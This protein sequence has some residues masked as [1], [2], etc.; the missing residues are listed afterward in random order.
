MLSI[1]FREEHYCP[2]FAD[3]QGRPK[4]NSSLT[5][6]GVEPS[7]HQGKCDSA[8]WSCIEIGYNGQKLSP[9]VLST[10]ST[11]NRYVVG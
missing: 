5:Q 1:S 8:L 11:D 2:Y 6:S 7:G 9:V 4:K 10:S 3:L